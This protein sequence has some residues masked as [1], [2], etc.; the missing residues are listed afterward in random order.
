MAGTRWLGVGRPRR[1]KMPRK[2][3]AE[4]W[5]AIST[6]YVAGSE[7][8]VPQSIFQRGQLVKSHRQAEAVADFCFLRISHGRDDMVGLETA[9]LSGQ[10]RLT[11][12]A[13]APRDLTLRKQTRYVKLL[14]TVKGK[15]CEK[16]GY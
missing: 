15:S 6:S 1:L 7:G 8:A 14:E 10:P 9:P 5:L 11:F 16:R 2:A 12:I 4:R 13:P 3:W